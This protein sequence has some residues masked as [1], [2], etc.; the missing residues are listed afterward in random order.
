M[1]F[2]KVVVDACTSAVLRYRS[3][4][5][6]GNDNTLSRSFLR[7]FVA[8][9]LYEGLDA[10]VHVDRP[11]TVMAL[12]LGMRP[13]RELVAF[14]G[15]TC[16]DVAVYDH[17]RPSRLVQFE[18]FDTASHLPP[19]NAGLDRA[20]FLARATKLEAYVAY[21]VCPFIISL[22][23]RI[24]RLHDLYGCD[25]YVGERHPSRDDKWKWCFVC[26]SLGERRRSP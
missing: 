13:E 20:D 25:M 14:L 23:S 1:L 10:E 15:S 22:E 9:R 5:R 7:S 3:M 2:Q 18:V 24:E 12:E 8:E 21:M 6:S 4:S 17:D 11:C 19:G 26:A 16:A